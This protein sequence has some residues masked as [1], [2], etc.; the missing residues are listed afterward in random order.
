MPTTISMPQLGETV[1][2]GTILEWVKQVGEHVAEDDVLV[3]ISTDK[4]DT[5][6]PSPASGILTEIL[7]PAGET[8]EVGTALAI[9]SDGDDDQPDEPAED[10]EGDGASSSETEPAAVGNAPDTAATGRGSVVEVAVTDGQSGDTSRRSVLSPV[11]RKLAADHDIDLAMVP[12]TGDGGRIT[13]KDVQAFID[14]GA[15]AAP[16][17]ATSAPAP[18]PAAAAPAPKPATPSLTPPP[19]P[20]GVA[21]GTDVQEVPRLRQRIAA[22]MRNAKDTAAHVWTSVEVDFENVEKVRAAHRASFKEQEGYSLTYLPFI[23]RA[24][25]DALKAY[26]VV[27]SRFDLDA[28]SWTF[29]RGVNLGIAVDLNQE[30]L[31]VVNIEG[32]DGMTLTGLARSIRT[33]AVAARDGKV[34]PDDLTGFSFSITNPGPFGSFMSAPIIPVPNAAI[35]STDTITKKP[36]VVELPDGSDTIAIRHVGYLGLSWDHRV[37]DGST[38]VLFLD[39]IKQNLQTWDWEQELS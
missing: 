37:F 29:H 36:V 5:E 15:A 13:R 32:A 33:M 28:G 31:V 17:A 19:A 27:N 25:M 9:L 22:N 6:V 23:A 38:A 34:G 14:G 1:T 30:G 20:A 2:E 11:V 4:V 39:R 35:L 26:P 7:V 21:A 24:T 8:V 12:G 3:E 10:E 18:A 16:A